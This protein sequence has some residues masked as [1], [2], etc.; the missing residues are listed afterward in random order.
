MSEGTCDM[1]AGFAYAQRSPSARLATV[2]IRA[3]RMLE[4]WGQ[5]IGRPVDH[6]AARRARVR[7]DAVD[8][9]RDA[10]DRARMLRGF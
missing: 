7:A 4:E 8:R 9:H 2:A 6:E 1:S 5:R 3:G 10:A